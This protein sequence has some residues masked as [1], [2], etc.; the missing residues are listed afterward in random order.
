V[1]ECTNANPK[2]SHYV[3]T[4]INTAKKGEQLDQILAQYEAGVFKARTAWRRIGKVW[5]DAK[6]S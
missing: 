4:E 6:E 1:E 3:V 2:M 5:D